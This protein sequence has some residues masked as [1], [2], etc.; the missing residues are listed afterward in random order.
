[1]FKF[2][3]VLLS[4][5][6]GI[7]IRLLVLSLAGIDN[8]GGVLLERLRVLLHNLLTKSGH[9]RYLLAVVWQ[10]GRTPALLTRGNGIRYFTLCLPI[11]IV[12]FVA[13]VLS[14]NRKMKISTKKKKKRC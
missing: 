12:R 14:K 11:V 6:S 10:S 7:G 4:A 13:K 1:M 9:A 2:S 8:I 3:I 5:N